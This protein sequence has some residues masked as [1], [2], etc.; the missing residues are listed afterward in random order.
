MHPSVH[1]RL[2]LIEGLALGR[3]RGVGDSGF[4]CDHQSA[5]N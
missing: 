4:V 2:D 5:Q 3:E 1:D